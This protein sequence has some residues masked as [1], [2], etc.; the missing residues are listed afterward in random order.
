MSS[1]KI[2]ITYSHKDE[3]FRSELEKHLSLLKRQGLIASWNDHMIVAGQEW[4]GEI[5]VHLN[6]AQIILLLISPDFMHSDY[7]Y[8][9]EMQR[10]MERHEAEEALIIP[11]ILR[12]TDWKGAL[13]GKLQ[14][15]PNNGKPITKRRNRDDAFLEI[16]MGIRKA[17]EE[18]SLKVPQTFSSSSSTVSHKISPIG[19]PRP[20]TFIGRNIYLDQLMDRLRRGETSGIFALNGMGGVGKTAIAAETIA[21][22]SQDNETFPGGAAWISCE[23]LVGPEGLRKIWKQLALVV[24]VDLAKDDPDIQRIMLRRALAR[25]P[26]I[27]LALDNIEPSLNVDILLDTL[28][29]PGHTTLLLTSRQALV[30]ER[31]TSFMIPPLSDSESTQLFAQRLKQLNDNRPLTHDNQKWL[32]Q[33][34]IAL[35]GLPLAIEL[36]AAYTG[37]QQ[38]PLFQIFRE[39]EQDKVAANSLN[40]D[41]RRALMSRF[42][43]S[44]NVL[45]PRE[46]RLFSGLSSL[47]GTDFPR[48]AATAIVFATL[49]IHERMAILGSPSED[50]SDLDYIYRNMV[51]PEFLRHSGQDIAKLVAYALIEP[52][53]GNMRLHIHPLLREYA[54]KR[55]SELPFDI[56]RNIQATIKAFWLKYDSEPS[57]KELSGIDADSIWEARQEQLK[58]E[59]NNQTTSAYLHTPDHYSELLWELGVYLVEHGEAEL[60]RTRMLESGKLVASQEELEKQRLEAKN[61][62]RSRWVVWIKK[63]RETDIG[64]FYDLLK[65]SVRI[66]RDLESDIAFV[67]SV[68]SRHHATILQL[69]EGIYGLRDEGSTNGTLLN[70]TRMVKHK[71]YALQSGDTIQ[72]RN[73]ILAFGT[74][75]QYFASTGEEIS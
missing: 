32:S 7:C 41:P 44:W 5:D 42:D 38:M 59:M 68:V 70:N 8:S 15:L 75:D 21:R 24:G 45:S 57:T 52:L 36:V 1:I 48:K 64:R 14:A 3:D 6:A 63:G 28:A 50:F 49:N 62:A 54:A 27:L 34:I 65:Q 71:I 9:I 2:F 55:L 25:S 23:D 18:L 29:I 43:R 56:R 66:G 13:F 53:P 67:D 51:K 30:P 31:L 20:A 19:L 69:S 58:E 17:I 60:G 11:I 73:T 16:A 22:L 47:R 61:V 12:P 37:I 26:R 46:Q 10:A 33:I 4:V 40:F 72:I 39:L 35:G 74:Y